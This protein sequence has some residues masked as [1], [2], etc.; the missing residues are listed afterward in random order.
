MLFGTPALL[1]RDCESRGVAERDRSTDARAAI[2]AHMA[3]KPDITVAAIT[4]ADGRFLVVEERINHRLVFNQPAGHVESGETI[5]AALVREV[6]E[7]TA[8]VF[9]PEAFLG[10][11]LWRSP[12]SGRATLRFAFSGAVADHNASQPLDR[13]IV[14]THWLSRA[15]L[16]ERA[17]RLRSP[18]VLRCVDDYLS[19]RRLPLDAVASLDPESAVEAG[20]VNL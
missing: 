20:A 12:S 3:W 5:I 7:E 2:M 14:R 9:I 16:I 4:E 1:N 17:P 10:V 8:W 11:Y 18:L 6:R 15:E 19:G 13:G